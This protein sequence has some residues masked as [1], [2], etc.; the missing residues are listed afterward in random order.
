MFRAQLH[1]IDKIGTQHQQK[2]IQGLI[3]DKPSLFIKIIGRT[4]E[5]ARISPIFNY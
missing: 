2:F 1:R 3:G 5:Q 4:F